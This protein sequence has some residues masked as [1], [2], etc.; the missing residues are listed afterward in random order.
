LV[1]RIIVVVGVDSAEDVGIRSD[2]VGLV[3]GVT[4][5]LVKRGIR[6]VVERGVGYVSE[7]ASL[8]VDV[9]CT[10]D[11]VHA[12]GQ[13]RKVGKPASRIILEI[14][15][16]LRDG[17][18]AGLA[19]LRHVGYS[20]EPIVHVAVLVI[21]AAADGRAG[22]SHPV[23]VVIAVGEIDPWCQASNVL[24]SLNSP[25]EIIVLVSIGGGWISHQK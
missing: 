16:L 10:G 3:V 22:R 14:D 19:S 17:V 7:P 2:S 21:I 11:A 9:V 4:V 24:R 12:V 20:T 13:A 5:R 8:V 6:D 1:R 23:G 25:I 18:P 15:I